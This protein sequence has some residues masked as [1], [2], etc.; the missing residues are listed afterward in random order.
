MF[1]RFA[2]A[3]A[4]IAEPLNPERK[5]A[6][7][8]DDDPCGARGVSTAPGCTL[9]NVRRGQARLSREDQG[10]P[11]GPTRSRWMARRGDDPVAPRARSP[12]DAWS[13]APDSAPAARAPR[14]R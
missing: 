14:P 1:E 3:T 2:I 13:G 9:G 4:N 8:G 10:D 12:R 6:V 5:S 11:S 7:K